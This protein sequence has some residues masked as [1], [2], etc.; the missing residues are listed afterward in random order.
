MCFL[1]FTKTM[2]NPAI[3][4]SPWVTAGKMTG[5]ERENIGP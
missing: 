5:A 4:T 3:I 1:S 2:K